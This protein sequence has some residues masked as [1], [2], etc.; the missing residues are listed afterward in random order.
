MKVFLEILSEIYEGGRA[1]RVNILLYFSL[2]HL[3]F[4]GLFQLNFCFHLGRCNA[5]INNVYS[6]RDRRRKDTD[7][8][9]SGES[10]Q[11]GKEIACVK[12][13]FPYEK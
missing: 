5:M 2:K 10:E 3:V 4:I 7:S 1:V 9:L 8:L 6:S 12:G 11:C 13:T